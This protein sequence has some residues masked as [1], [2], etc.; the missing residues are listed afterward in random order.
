MEET[1]LT[2]FDRVR[3]A[4]HPD[5]PYTADLL[6]SIFTDFVEIHGDRRYGRRFR[7]SSADL[8]NSTAMT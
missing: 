8:Q 6:E 3:N 7:R 1:E 5:R 2:A 4:R